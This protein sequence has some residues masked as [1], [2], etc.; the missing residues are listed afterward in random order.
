MRQM[1]ERGRL[2][3][4]QN[5]LDYSERRRPYGGRGGRA[6]GGR[7]GRSDD[8]SDTEGRDDDDRGAGGGAPPR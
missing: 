7:G 1:E 2:L 4:Q 3:A 6:R 5:G 8:G